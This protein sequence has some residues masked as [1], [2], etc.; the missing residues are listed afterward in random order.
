LLPNKPRPQKS[1]RRK[2]VRET[3]MRLIKTL[4]AASALTAM[5]AGG[6]YAKTLVYCSEG[7]PEGFDPGLY[8]SG[9]TLDVNVATY[10]GL[11]KFKL[12]S[13]EVEPALAEKWEISKDGLTYTFHLR[14]GVKWQ[15]TDFFTPTREFNAD[16]V[17]YSFQRQI[18]G[19]TYL[20]DTTFAYWGDMSMPDQVADMKKVDDYTVVLTLKTPSS[21]MI[22][23]LAMP[24]AEVVSEEYADGLAKANNLAQLNDKPVGTGP[25]TFVNYQ[26]DANIRFKANADYW[27]GAP[28]VDLVYSINKDATARL[29]SLKAGECDVMAYPNP[30]DVDAIKKDP[31]FQAIQEKGLNFGA[32]W[33]NTQEK[34]FDNVEVR[35]ALD[36]AIDKKSLIAAVYQGQGQIATSALPPTMWGYNSSIKGY[37]YDPAAAKKMLEKAGVKDLTLKIW[38]MPVARPYM[39]DAKRAAE[40]MQADFAKIGVTAT[41]Y[42]V[43]WAEY[44]KTS[45]PVDRDG[46]VIIGWTGD[47]GDPDN[48]FTP[49]FGCDAVGGGN[50]A[51]WCNKDFDA[52]LKKAQQVTDQ[53]DR[54]KLYEQAQEIFFKDDPVALL[55]HSL[56]TMPMSKKVS[57]YVIDPFG[58]HHF[59]TVDKSE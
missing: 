50:R 1:R 29:Q 14:H 46:A 8:E 9:T 6:A 17:I 56:V 2:F 49:N 23:N 40:L 28:K 25:F 32:L 45:K 48:F 27:G 10:E 22:A 34:P 43:D 16:D 31:A 30:A 18:K 4:L 44:L 54:A 51:Q 39:P 21:P 5:L 20:P 38:A 59:E 35:K 19:T 53:K 47:N 55:A 24:F 42:S 7:S 52:L 58:L 37:P 36:M 13:T 15:T 26:K 11:V 57:G 33:F 12:G 41:I 3:L